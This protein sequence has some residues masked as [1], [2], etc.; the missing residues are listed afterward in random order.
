MCVPS[1]KYNSSTGESSSIGQRADPG[2]AATAAG[3]GSAAGAG[4]ATTESGSATAVDATD[5]ACAHA[6][7]SAAS[8]SVTP[9]S[10]SKAASSET[11]AGGTRAEAPPATSSEA[12]ERDTL[13]SLPEDA[14]V[15]KLGA[16][17]AR[18]YSAAMWASMWANWASTYSG[19]EGKPACRTTL[20]GVTFVATV[21]LRLRLSGSGA[22]PPAAAGV[23]TFG[24][25][26]AA[27]PFASA[28]LLVP[29]GWDCSASATE[30]TEAAV[31]ERPAATMPA[32]AC[33]GASGNSC[34]SDS[35]QHESM[36][37]L[38]DCCEL[39]KGKR[40]PKSPA[41][42]PTPP[43]LGAALRP[44]R[45][46]IVSWGRLRLSAARPPLYE[47]KGQAHFWGRPKHNQAIVANFRNRPGADYDHNQ[48][49]RWTDGGV[50]DA[51]PQP[52]LTT[53]AVSRY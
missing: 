41:P 12:V 39:S 52:S 10:A 22:T 48:N 45:C 47:R 26:T 14:G 24:G 44:P 23:D 35:S 25:A 13:P 50:S 42:S 2:T 53:S 32:V 7:A 8:K 17:P 28:W 37:S 36:S 16:V 5:E 46:A 19:R 4:T 38:S 11:G 27:E 43:V 51:T 3:S 9:S 15:P 1:A 49:S 34:W 31:D 6:A 33:G 29:T 18:S 21:N 30:R 20:V 40:V